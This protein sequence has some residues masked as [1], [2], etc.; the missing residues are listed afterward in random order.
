MRKAYFDR[1]TTKERRGRGNE[2]LSLFIIASMSS[3]MRRSGKL[4][5]P[6]HRPG[7][8]GARPGPPGIRGPGPGVVFCLV[9]NLENTEVKKR[10][11][12]KVQPVRKAHHA[13]G[14]GWKSHV[15]IKSMV[16]G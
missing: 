11:G 2:E 5:G 15:G 6:A 7:K 3:K 1:G 4:A 13:V 8:R 10:R 12:P 16:V 14:H 9:L